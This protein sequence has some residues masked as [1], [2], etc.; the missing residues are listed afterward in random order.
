MGTS[1]CFSGAL[2]PTQKHLWGFSVEGIWWFKI[3]QLMLLLKNSSNKPK[4]N[5]LLQG[6]TFLRLHRQ[7]GDLAFLHPG[8]LSWCHPSPHPTFSSGPS[9]SSAPHPPFS[10]ASVS[11]AG[12]CPSPLDVLCESRGMIWNCGSLGFTWS[13]PPSVPCPG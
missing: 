5:L 4:P 10:S 9:S 11:A 8:L 3:L 6:D 7:S 1:L 13:C 2:F 12:V